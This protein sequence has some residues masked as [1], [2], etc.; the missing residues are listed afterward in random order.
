M[1]SCHSYLVKGGSRRLFYLLNKVDIWLISRYDWYQTETHVIISI[2]LK[3]VK[4]E[5]LHVGVDEST[6]RLLLKFFLL[7]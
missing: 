4:K 6:V 1:P 5:D 3:N 7:I 2:M